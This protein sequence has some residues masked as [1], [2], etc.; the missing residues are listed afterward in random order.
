MKTIDLTKEELITTNGG[1]EFS[2]GIFR[3][4]G[5]LTKSATYVNMS[6]PAN[7]I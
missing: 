3:L 7:K 5:L 4:L 2:E 1:S 6:D